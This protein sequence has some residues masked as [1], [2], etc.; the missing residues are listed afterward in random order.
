MFD[1]GF[2]K[3]RDIVNYPRNQENGNIYEW[4]E[5]NKKSSEKKVLPFADYEYEYLIQEG[6]VSKKNETKNNY[7]NKR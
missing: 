1:F 7:R 6:Y 3:E 4:F 5:S 2:I